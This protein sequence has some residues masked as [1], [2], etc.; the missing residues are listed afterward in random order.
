MRLFCII[1]SPLS[2]VKCLLLLLLLLPPCPP[3]VAEY[4]PGV[5]YS[6]WLLPPYDVFAEFVAA[7]VAV[8]TGDEDVFNG[9][10]WMAAALGGL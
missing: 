8:V 4:I 2:C 5:L 1:G 10:C 3:S 7:V 6:C 9:F